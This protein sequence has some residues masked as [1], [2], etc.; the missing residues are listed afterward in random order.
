MWFYIRVFFII[1]LSINVKIYFYTEEIITLDLYKSEGYRLKVFE[2]KVV[3]NIF[4]PKR[5]E[6]IGKWRK[7]LEGEH[8]GLYSSPNVV[9]MI[10]SLKVLC[11]G[12]IVHMV[13]RSV[14]G[15]GGDLG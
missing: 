9:R 14:R 2:N 3:K 10:K 5:T 12:H 15:E 8:R 1:S 4:R 6:I 11:A 7:V 13:K